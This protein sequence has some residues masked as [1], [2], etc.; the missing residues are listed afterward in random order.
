MK[1]FNSLKNVKIIFGENVLKIQKESNKYYL[2][3][4]KNTNFETDLVYCATG[5]K[6]NT[7]FLQQNFSQFLTKDNSVRVNKY[8]QLENSTAT[9]HNIFAV[10]DVVGIDG[11]ERL[12]QNAEKHAEIVIE[13]INLLENRKKL[14]EYKQNV[15]PLIISLGP[16]NAMLVNG[17]QV[18]FEKKLSELKSIVESNIMK[19]LAMDTNNK[20]MI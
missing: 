20:K 13:N 17:S 10:G 3:T 5:F 16:E 8:L 11:E 18:I 15:R 9:L 19:G 7:D 14:V 12:A 2:I 4:E 6:P 1:F